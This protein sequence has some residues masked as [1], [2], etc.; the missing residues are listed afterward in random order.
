MFFAKSSDFTI[1]HSTFIDK[2]N[3]TQNKLISNEKRGQSI[4]NGFQML[5]DASSM[6]ATFDSQARNPPPQCHPSTRK[7][8]LDFIS[9]W[10]EAGDENILFLDGPAGAGKTAI[11]QTVAE[12]CAKKRLLLAS[13]F[14]FKDSP[15]RNTIIYL[16]P[17]FAS[18]IATSSSRKRRKIEKTIER[19]PPILTKSPS[20]QARELILKMYQPSI[21]R[22]HTWTKR[23]PR[24]LII[25]GL[26]ECDDDD[27]QC[28]IVGL[29]GQLVANEHFALRCLVTSRPEPHILSAMNSLPMRVARVSLNE[30]IWDATDDVRLF[31]RFKFDEIAKRI[32]SSI[33]R[34]WPSDEIINTLVQKAGGIFI[35]A[36]TVLKYVD[37]RDSLP[38]T[39]LEHILALSPGP[40]PFAELD[41]LYEH[42]LMSCPLQHRSTLLHIFGFIFLH[43]PIFQESFDVSLIEELLELSLGEVMIV[44]R[45][46]HSILTIMTDDTKE[47]VHFLHA[48]FG[49]FLFNEH[50]SGDF[51]I[52][53]R[54][55]NEYLATKCI[56]YLGY[57]AQ[58]CSFKN[59]TC[60]MYAWNS[61]FYHGNGTGGLFLV[62]FIDELSHHVKVLWGEIVF[63]ESFYRS[64]M[65]GL[66]AGISWLQVSCP[67]LT[68]VELV[69][70]D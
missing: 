29:L 28:Q 42:I 16:I 21:F 20:V 55:E 14:F 3:I 48:S 35:Y 52:D 5:L 13:Y 30:P 25:D 44:L 24:L 40:R 60:I 33:P 65:D 49:D 27:A 56:D 70:K 8:L 26:D 46:M 4:G 12:I 18:Q 67:L 17:T 51:Y 50:R 47:T 23:K 10:V 34:P 43:N 61:W 1:N 57:R 22:K 58:N 9:N 38:T 45:R 6:D 32:P 39:Q 11:T 69:F 64:C 7:D 63:P 66:Q 53:R 31:F 68:N 41:K 37:D 59:A 15:S 2:S 54:R 19:D 36:S 62:N